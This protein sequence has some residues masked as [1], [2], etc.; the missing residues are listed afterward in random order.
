LLERNLPKNQFLEQIKK[1]ASS[2]A[3]S[4]SS[5]ATKKPSKKGFAGLLS[6]RKTQQKS[7]LLIREANHN[8]SGL[9]HTLLLHLVGVVMG[10]LEPP[11]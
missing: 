5:R 10:G 3:K 2:L 4:Y 6:N 9:S 8:T 11:T 7:I 1:I